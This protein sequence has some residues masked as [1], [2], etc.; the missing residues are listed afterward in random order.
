MSGGL[1]IKDD[2]ELTRVSASL[3]RRTETCKPTRRCW[4]QGRRARV[5]GWR[6]RSRQTCAT[7]GSELP[8]VSNLDRQWL[9]MRSR[10]RGTQQLVFSVIP[11]EAMRSDTGFDRDEF[12]RMM[13]QPPRDAITFD[14]TARVEASVTDLL[15]LASDPE[16]VRQLDPRVQAVRLIWDEQPM[17][18]AE[19]ELDVR[20]SIP[21]VARALEDQS[22]VVHRLTGRNSSS[23]AL[24]CG[25]R[26]GSA[27][28]EVA[29][30]AIGRLKEPRVEFSGWVRASRSSTR[31]ALRAMRPLVV[32]LMHRSLHR[33]ASKAARFIE[34]EIDLKGSQL[35]G[36]LEF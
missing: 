9:A 34:E 12:L 20:F 7:P 28:I 17:W 3:G 15:S 30:C 26:G 19:V 31:S 1:S 24:A 33:T 27:F 32:L 23:V 5:A 16:R 6:G 2:I 35:A 10:G 22:F 4:L 36:D 29:S 18:S 25:G 21:L 11:L 14:T 13:R 8:E